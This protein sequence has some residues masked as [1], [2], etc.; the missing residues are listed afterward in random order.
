MGNR[1]IPTPSLSRSSD[2][3]APPTSR[4]SGYSTFATLTPP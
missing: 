4:R 3:S 1:F 2:C